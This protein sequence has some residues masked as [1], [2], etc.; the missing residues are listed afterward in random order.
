VTDAAWISPEQRVL[1]ARL[2]ELIRQYGPARFTQAHLVRAD[3][4]DFPDPWE[5]TL[6][7]LYR[8][9]HRLFWHAHIT[10]EVVVEDARPRHDL[11]QGMLR[12][13]AIDFLEAADGKAIFQ[14][15]QFGN[16]DVAGLLSHAVGEAF[17]ALAP[18]SADPFR[19]VPT[20][21][22]TV[23]EASLAACYLGLGV[24]VANAS[25]YRRHQSRIVGRETVSETQIE[26]TGGLSIADAT[27]LLAVQ[28][29]VRDDVPA[30]P[31]TLHGA[32]KEW[33]ERW[34]TVLEPHEDELVEILGLD[35]SSP[36]TLPERAAA[37]RPAPDVAEPAPLK[38]Y[39]GRESFRRPA[40]LHHL[41]SGLGAG[42]VLSIAYAALIAPGPA[43][44][45]LWPIGAVGGLL[46]SRPGFKCNTCKTKMATELAIC[47]TCRVTLVDTLATRALRK[48]RL[49]EY[50]RLR[51]EIDP[52]HAE[53]AE[54]AYHPDV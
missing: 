41:W 3:E 8:L 35:D 48:A 23:T 15:A 16:D 14:V 27:L 20:S 50:A 21:E 29:T 33:L 31:E 10:A 39:E 28:L 6:A 34:L 54:S 46:L 4:R 37:P 7:S 44:P 47:P 24:L 2:G 52:E 53:E 12:K 13:S 22:P 5:P 1:V 26:K 11:R 40:R 49:A 42:V 51:E 9:L 19:P 32:Q 36:A 45:L 18:S 38:V 25:M 43:V 17:L 30:A